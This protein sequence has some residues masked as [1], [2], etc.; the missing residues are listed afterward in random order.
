MGSDTDHTRN[1]AQVNLNVYFSCTS[2]HFN[3]SF[4]FY[5]LS[6]SVLHGGQDKFLIIV[7]PSAL[8]KHEGMN[9]NSCGFQKAQ[10]TLSLT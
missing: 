2:C 9:C 5:A 1:D 10:H 6:R 3:E 8:Q 7:H 4:T